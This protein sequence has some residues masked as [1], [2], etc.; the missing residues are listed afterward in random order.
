MIRILLVLAFSGLL[1]MAGRNPSSGGGD[2]ATLPPS[3][4]MPELTLPEDAKRHLIAPLHCPE[5]DR[6]VID[7][8][9]TDLNGGKGRVWRVGFQSQ[10]SYLEI[11]QH[12][13]NCLQQKGVARLYDIDMPSDSSIGGRKYRSDDQLTFVE[14][15]YMNQPAIPL[16]KRP[17]FQGWTLSLYLMDTP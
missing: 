16:L 4:P 17:A 14:V 15:L 7:A 10:L 13:D 6:A 8:A 3:W 1:S 2:K 11:L 9:A 5:Q 12:F